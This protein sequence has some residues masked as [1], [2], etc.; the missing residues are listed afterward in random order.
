LRFP[1]LLALLDP[2]RLPKMLTLLDPP[3]LPKLLDFLDLRHQT[4]PALLDP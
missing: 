2:P 3:R 1:E 4:M